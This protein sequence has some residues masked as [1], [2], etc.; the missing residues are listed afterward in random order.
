[1]CV[2]FIDKYLIGRLGSSI[3]LDTVVPKLVHETTVNYGNNT[4]P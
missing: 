1:M 3:S 4:W 2:H